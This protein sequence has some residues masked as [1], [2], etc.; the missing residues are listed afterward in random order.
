MGNISEG[1]QFKANQNI[2]NYADHPNFKACNLFSSLGLISNRKKKLSE[3]EK[4]IQI[5]GCPVGL[6]QL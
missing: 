2:Q 5:D 6:R 1:K 3:L 4:V